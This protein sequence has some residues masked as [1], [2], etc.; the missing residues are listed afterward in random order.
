MAGYNKYIGRVVAVQSKMTIE[1][2]DGTRIFVEAPA[3]D[4]ID[5]EVEVYASQAR[6]GKV[7][8]FG[9]W[10][11]K[12]GGWLDKLVARALSGSKKGA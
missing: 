1:L 8:G 6:D 7:L 10:N 3:Q 2:E 4:L 9:G 12:E 11:F 5:R